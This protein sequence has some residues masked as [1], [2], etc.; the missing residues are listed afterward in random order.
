M[1]II[2]VISARGGSTGLPNKNI[3]LLCGKPLIFWSIKQA[4]KVSEL[5]GIFVSTDS[6]LIAKSSIAAGATVPFLRSEN[7]SRK[8]TPKFQVWKDAL[9]K[10]EKFLKKKIDIF[11]DLD[12]T[13]PLRSSQDIKKSIQKLLKN[14]SACDGVVSV[15]LSRKN[16]YF[17][18]MEKDKKGFFMLSKKLKKWPAAR[19]LAPQVYDQVA[20]IYCFKRE[21]IIN[22]KSIY[23]GKILGHEMTGLKSFDIDSQLDFEIIEFLF[24]KY[25]F[26]KQ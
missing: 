8:F 3:K 16:P 7:I 12:C 6:Q 1:N 26:N 10:I 24:K 2:C 22:K 5:N 18:M 9:I 20:S 21:F 19:Q 25:K 11:V 15:S 4:Q 17:N 23:D 13:N 14:Y